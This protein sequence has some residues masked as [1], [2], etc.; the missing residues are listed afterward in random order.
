[1]LRASA[2]FSRFPIL[3]FWMDILLEADCTGDIRVLSPDSSFMRE[4]REIFP[5]LFVA[6]VLYAF[7]APAAIQAAG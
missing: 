6:H 7:Q 2:A 5:T 3:G 1:M 4:G